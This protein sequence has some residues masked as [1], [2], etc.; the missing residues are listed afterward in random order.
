MMKLFKGYVPTKDK[1]CLIKYKDNAKLRSYEEVEN[2]SEYAGILSESVILID[3]DDYEQSEILLNI[4]DE[5]EIRCRVYKTTRGKHFLFKNIDNLGNI[6][7]PTCK[8]KCQLACGL[9]A[10]IKVGCKNSYSILRFNGSDREIIYD[11]FDDEDYEEIP[12]WLLPIRHSFEFLTMEA[13]DG[14]NQSL[15]NYILTLQSNDF[16][17]DEARQT[18]KI[19]N[20]Y[21]LKDPLDENEID[22]ILRDEA[23]QKPVFF[24]RT[25]AFL[26]DRFASYIKSNNHIIKINGQLHIY[27]D[28]IYVNNL[29]LIES[30]MIQYIPGLNKAKRS[31]TITYLDLLINQDAETSDAEYIAFKNGIYN[32]IMDE[33]MPFSPQYIITNKIDYDY[34][35]DAYSELVDKTLDKLSCYD[36][37]IR[38]LLE[39]V[40]GYTFYR[41]NELRKAFILIGDKVNGKST[42]LDMIKTLLGDNNTVALDLGELSDKF[43]KAELFGKLAN[44]GDDI[45]DSFISNTAVFKKLVSGDRLNA[46]RKGQDPFDFNNYA[47]MLFSANEIPRMKD[48]SG[49]VLSR[50]IIVPFNAK[51]LPT[52]PDFDP[53]IKYK[54]RQPECMEYLIQLGLKGLKN[55][56]QYQ[57][58]TESE[59]AQAELEKYEEQNNPILLFFKEDVKIENEP[60]NAVYRKYLEFCNINSFK[61]MSNIEFSKQV[62]K[63][64]GFQII[65]KTIKNKK[66]RIFVRENMGKE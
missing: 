30:E 27:K 3:I 19:I 10:D 8:T 26:F 61:P 36:K 48:K 11:I 52:D 64:L 9:T 60:T 7:Q 16:S 63:K 66:Y 50:L 54:L 17:V 59:K 37:S 57:Q 46:E 25:G 56:L 21:I 34:I 28:G 14:R 24:T 33:F 44:I 5:L 35:P 40:I 18:I 4:I 15:F 42:Y 53:Y 62:K 49:A 58:F 31:E 55:V 12:K 39:E 29:K 1:K 13:G 32:I 23:F 43:K 22:T 6:L 41:R 38:S 45:D 47:K 51:F 65:N 20:K 2:L